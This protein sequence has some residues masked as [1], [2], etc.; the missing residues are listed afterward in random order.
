M[1]HSVP[2]AYPL[3]EL[4][5]LDE[6][7]LTQ[8]SPWTQLEVLRIEVLLRSH[9][10]ETICLHE[11]DAE[12]MVLDKYDL[13]ILPV[14]HGWHHHL[15]TPNGALGRAGITDL[16]AMAAETSDET[17]ARWICNMQPRESRYVYLRIDAAQTPST[18]LTALRPLLRERHAQ[19]PPQITQPESYDVKIGR[20]IFRRFQHASHSQRKPPFTLQTWLTYLRCYDVHRSKPTLSHGQIAQKIYPDELTSK[21]TDRVK[22]ALARLPRLMAYAEREDWRAHWPPPSGF[23]RAS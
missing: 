17:V 2:P 15:L 10:V 12:Q 11:P 18:I 23:L 1:P 22:K 6:V 13:P 5:R 14:L 4:P 3:P 19:L 9:T 21:S 8:V 7:D 20:G 16:G